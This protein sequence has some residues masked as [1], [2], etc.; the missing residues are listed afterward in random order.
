MAT[1]SRWAARSSMSYFNQQITRMHGVPG[2]SMV[3]K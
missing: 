2:G 1:L 3:S